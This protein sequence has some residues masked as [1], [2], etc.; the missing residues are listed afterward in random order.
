MVEKLL[1]SVWF[2]FVSAYFYDKEDKKMPIKEISELGSWNATDAKYPR[3]N[4]ERVSG[5]DCY[6]IICLRFLYGT[7]STPV[8][9]PGRIT[10]T[11]KR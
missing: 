10:D 9:R 6:L 2:F 5:V 7:Q 8:L 1:E 11:G 3:S 4:V